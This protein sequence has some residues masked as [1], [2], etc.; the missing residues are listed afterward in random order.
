[1]DG[2]CWRDIEADQDIK[3][4]KLWNF[5]SLQQYPSIESLLLG[6]F[7]LLFRVEGSAS[8][9]RILQYSLTCADPLH[10]PPGR[11]Y[12]VDAGYPNIQGFLSSYCHSRYCRSDFNRGSQNP[13][14]YKEIF[15]KTHALLRNA[16]ERVFDVLKARFPT[17]KV[18]AC[19]KPEEDFKS[20]QWNVV[21][22]AFTRA[23]GMVLKRENFKNKLKH[24][25]QTTR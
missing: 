11:Y 16:I 8:D 17:L 18:Q 3:D 9:S 21:E 10:V 4:L 24:G 7:L 19:N 14:D 25:V 12:L 15:N 22:K 5:L 2:R 6:W 13:Q 20:A 23:I 1:M